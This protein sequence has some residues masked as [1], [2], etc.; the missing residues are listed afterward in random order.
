MGLKCGSSRRPVSSAQRRVN[1]V[2]SS[3]SLA[4]S[5]RR[6]RASRCALPHHEVTAKRRELVSKTGPYPDVRAHGLHEQARLHARAGAEEL[7]AAGQPAP[8]ARAPRSG[9]SGAPDRRPPRSAT[10]KRRTPSP[11]RAPRTATLHA[12][13]GRPSGQTLTRRPRF[14]TSTSGTGNGPGRRRAR[15]RH[16]RR[17]QDQSDRDGAQ[18]PTLEEPC[19]R[20]AVGPGFLARVSRP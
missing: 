9:D 10:P 15:H 7:R 11:P 19:E 6:D 18:L 5:S 13:R 4:P 20:P 14:P 16:E 17:G 8:P 2:S 12:R 1:R 3:S